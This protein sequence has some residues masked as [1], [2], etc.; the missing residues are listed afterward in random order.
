MKSATGVS[1]SRKI[2]DGRVSLEAVCKPEHTAAG[3]Q[4]S[5]SSVNRRY[6]AAA[7][8]AAAMLKRQQQHP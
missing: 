3:R 5:S 4:P 6:L 1:E 2:V 7:T 8:A